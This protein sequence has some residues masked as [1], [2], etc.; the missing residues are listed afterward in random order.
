MEPAGTLERPVPKHH[1]ARR[2]AP[3]ADVKADVLYVSSI[4]KVHIKFL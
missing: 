2:N 1:T 4:Y 3:E